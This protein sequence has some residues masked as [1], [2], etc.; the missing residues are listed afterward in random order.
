MLLK[1]LIPTKQ[2]LSY[3]LLPYSC[4]PTCVM[5]AMTVLGKNKTSD[6]IEFVY[7]LLR[8][9]LKDDGVYGGHEWNYVLEAIAKRAGL[10]ISGEAHSDVAP[11]LNS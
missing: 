3:Q 4:W 9:V 1:K 10:K 2:P 6:G 7:R 8:T 5:N 11:L